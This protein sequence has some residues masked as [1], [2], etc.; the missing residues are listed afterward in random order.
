M[1]SADTFTGRLRTYGLLTFDGLSQPHDTGDRLDSGAP[2]LSFSNPIDARDARRDPHPAGTRCGTA[3]ATIDDSTVGI[4]PA[5]LAPNT[6]YTVTI[7][8][9]LGDTFGHTLG[10]S[11]PR[12]V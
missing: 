1:L 8:A 7:D 4:N 5:L 2:E 10:T 6:D 12:D 3:V 9:A 11:A